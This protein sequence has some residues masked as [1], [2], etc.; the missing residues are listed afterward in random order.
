MNTIIDGM[1][2]I[3]R[4]PPPHSQYRPCS[5]G[6]VYRDIHHSEFYGAYDG[7][8]EFDVK[9][10]KLEP[11]RAFLSLECVRSNGHNHLSKKCIGGHDKASVRA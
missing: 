3:P 4:L 6:C 10:K 11:P 8:G 9:A 2:T 7:G 1:K 5:D